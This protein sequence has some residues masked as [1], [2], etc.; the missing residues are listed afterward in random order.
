MNT[1]FEFLRASLGKDFLDQY[2]E[3][4]ILGSTKVFDVSII[5]ETISN[6]KLKDFLRKNDCDVN[7]DMLDFF[8]LLRDET[9]EILVLYDPFELLEN[10]S[11]Y[12]RAENIEEDFSDLESIEV[13]K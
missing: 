5:E 1:W 12:L 9:Q 7:E 8:L 6:Q 4:Y 2:E 10:E 11:V 3:I 13:V